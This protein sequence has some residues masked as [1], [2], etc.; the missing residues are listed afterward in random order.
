MDGWVCVFTSVQVINVVFVACAVNYLVN[1]KPQ[2]LRKYLVF[3][4][5]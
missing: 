2:I 3:S 4:V 5:N 1:F